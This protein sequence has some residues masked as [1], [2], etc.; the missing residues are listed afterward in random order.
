MGIFEEYLNAA[1]RRREEKEAQAQAQAAL[2]QTEIDKT[3]DGFDA[4]RRTASAQ[5]LHEQAAQAEQM[6][7]LG[8]SGSGYAQKRA[9][10]Q[11]DSFQG[12]VV[13]SLAD[14]T[15]QTRAMMDEKNLAYQNLVNQGEQ[16]ADALILQ[17]LKE[18]AEQQRADD[19]LAFDREQAER[20]QQNWEEEQA[21]RRRQREEDFAAAQRKAD[22]DA[23]W[24]MVRGGRRD[25]K[26]RLS[27]HPL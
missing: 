22:T 17:G 12:Q 24:R 13:S 14:Q 25:A 19:A 15:A 27:H 3:V 18:Q 10:A 1:R 6:A 2:T 23:A 4:L 8:V 7:A 21:E 5:N 9:Q 11:Q 16:E 26:A 20:L